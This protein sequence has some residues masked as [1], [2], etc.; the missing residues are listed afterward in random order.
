MKKNKR[1]RKKEEMV[2]DRAV[3][4]GLYNEAT[5]KFRMRELPSE[6]WNRSWG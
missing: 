4:E 5:F 6:G 2:L 3:R 1:L